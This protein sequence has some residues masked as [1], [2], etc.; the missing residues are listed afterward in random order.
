MARNQIKGTFIWIMF[1]EINPN[2]I[3][4]LS[5]SIPVLYRILSFFPLPI[6]NSRV[7]RNF[8]PQAGV[9][10]MRNNTPPFPPS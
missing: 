1:V 10:K 3:I 7:A 8:N 6:N 2:F 4:Q 9:K 5:L